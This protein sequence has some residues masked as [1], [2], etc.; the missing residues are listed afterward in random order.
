M[1]NWVGMLTL[2][3]MVLGCASSSRPLQ[4]VSGGEPQYPSQAKTDGIEGYVVVR[5]DVG[6]DGKVKNA[7]VV[8]ADPPGVF[9]AA[10]LAAIETYQFKAQMVDG[11]STTVEGL[12]SKVVFE[13][14]EKEEY[15]K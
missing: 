3:L 14:G 4:Y 15:P 1:K 13:L 12:T 7:E 10:A 2:A 9:D 5:Y 8:A 11:V 6:A